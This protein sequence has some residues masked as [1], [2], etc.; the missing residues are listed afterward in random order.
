MSGSKYGKYKKR[1]VGVKTL[2]GKLKGKHKNIC[3]GG[4]GGRQN[5]CLRSKYRHTEV[6]RGGGG[7]VLGQNYI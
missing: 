3:H 1:N 6:V 7:L 5:W 4:G 2:N